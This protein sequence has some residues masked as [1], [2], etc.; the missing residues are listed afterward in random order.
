[1]NNIKLIYDEL[2]QAFGH[3]HWWPYT[4][5]KNKKLEISLG[6]ILTQNTNWQN[7][8]KALKN[9]KSQKLFSLKRLEDINT[10]RLA[11][12]IKPSGYYNQKAKKIKEFI[13]FLKSNKEISRENLLSV[14]GIG[15]ETADS[16]LLYAYDNPIF[17]VDAYT[18]RVMSRLGFKEE[19]YDELQGLFM[20]ELPEDAQLYNEYHALLV[21]LGKDFCKTKPVCEWC[22]LRGGVCSFK[23]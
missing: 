23:K 3:Q 6:A 16:I 2:F 18:K 1:M 10:K 8:E 7:V 21:R 20:Q 4:D 9:L 11:A 5:E 14:W 19:T 13:S 17:V 22:P 12:L 15:P